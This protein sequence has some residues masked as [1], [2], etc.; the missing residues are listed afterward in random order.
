MEA[1]MVLSG[2]EA[3]DYSGAHFRLQRKKE[4]RSYSD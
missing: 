3:R 4:R 2:R 1:R